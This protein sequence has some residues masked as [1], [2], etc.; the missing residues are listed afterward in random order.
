MTHV[1][2]RFVTCLCSSSFPCST[3]TEL[4]AG[5][6]GENFT[7]THVHH[8]HNTN[9]SILQLNDQFLSVLSRLSSVIHMCIDPHSTEPLLNP[10]LTPALQT[11]CHRLISGHHYL[12]RHKSA[13]L[14]IHRTD[15]IKEVCSL[16]LLFPFFF[17]LFLD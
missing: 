4:F 3:Q 8:P 9:V 11:C 2:M 17:F 1:P 6:T 10:H 15:D 5:T 12:H 14:Q 13:A 16:A 7:F